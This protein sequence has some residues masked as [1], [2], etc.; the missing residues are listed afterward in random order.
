MTLDRFE[1]LLRAAIGLDAASIGS[2]ALERAVRE[3]AAACGCQ[4][5]DAYW[6]LVSGSNDER[7]LLIEAVVVP[8]TW[9][10]RDPA[11]FEALVALAKAHDAT[12]LGHRPLRLLSAPSSTGEEPYSM[13]M[14][15]LDAGLAPARF[16][17]DALDV[18]VRAL[19]VA[20]AGCY[21]KNSFRGA[22]QAFRA[23]HF[24]G[25]RLS[26]SVRACVRFHHANL[27]EL[28]GSRGEASYDAIFCRNLLIYFD[29]ATQDRALA[30]LSSLLAERGALFVGPSESGL[31]LNHG[32][33][34]LSWPMSFAFR[35]P[36]PRRQGDARPA[37]APAG[38][39]RPP[40]PPI[41]AAGRPATPRAAQRS[42][43]LQAA[44]AAAP[45]RELRAAEPEPADSLEHARRLA[46]LGDVA[47]ARTCC[48]RF[49]RAHGPSAEAFYLLGLLHDAADEA[50]QAIEQYRRALY[51]DPQYHE[52]L[53]HL[54]VLVEGRGDAAGARRLYERARRVASRS[55]GT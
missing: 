44:A 40:M 53:I 5:L 27:L 26:E 29:R 15:L 4:D 18:S 2:G 1:A 35:R 21:K 28:D 39:A 24:A 3:R 10:F 16:A 51:L 37:R 32:F 22:D 43:P 46:D 52:A 25:D 55:T 6:S 45:L 41:G 50:T 19:E 14:A 23:R 7:Q 34:S 33:E 48:E 36:P 11:A 8:E 12:P 17:I 9:F 31:L 54:A 49:V 13:A 38:R 30:V 47:A 20:R 42:V